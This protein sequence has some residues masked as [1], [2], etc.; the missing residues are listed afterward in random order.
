MQQQKLLPGNRLAHRRD[1]DEG[2]RQHH[3]IQNENLRN[4]RAQLL[5]HHAP[6][7]HGVGQQEFRRVVALLLGEGV[8]RDQGGEERAA[9]PHHVA[10]LDGVKAGQLT[11]VQPVHAEGR[12]EAA[13]GGEDFAHARHLLLH[14]GE[15]QQ[16]DHH[17][18]ADAARPHRQRYPAL[19]QLMLE[20]NHAFAPPSS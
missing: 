10:A 3:R 8:D 5:R 1:G 9:Q 2:Q 13:H 14:F 15:Q 4:H 20:Q 17:Q 7:G 16:A 11:E 18:Q 12:R 6:A 19:A